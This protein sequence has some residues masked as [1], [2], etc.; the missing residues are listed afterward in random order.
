[1]NEQC[2]IIEDLLPLYHD[3]VCSV[4]SKQMVEEHLSQCEQCRSL[5]D[6]IDGEI[7]SS[8]K[9]QDV[10]TLN[11]IGKAVSKRKRKAFIAGVSIVLCVLTVLFVGA[12]IWWYFH[13]YRYYSAFTEGQTKTTLEGNI[14]A[15]IKPTEL[16]TWKDDTYQYYVVVPDFLDMGGFAGMSRLDNTETQTVELAVTRWDHEKYLFHIFINDAEKTRYFIVDRE[17]NLCGNYTE[18][19][20]ED[21]QTELDEWSDMVQTLIHDALATWSFLS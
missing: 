12:S 3:G 21:T 5:L 18:A 7:G 15:E 4:E 10:K 13:E 9:S 1:M 20:R 16:Y 19:Q 11:S 17:G 14:R 8:A 6:R 2:K